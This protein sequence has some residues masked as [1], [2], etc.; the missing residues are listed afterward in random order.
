MRNKESA[1]KGQSSLELLVTLSFGLIILLPIVA[2]AFLQISSSSSTLSAT[3]AQQVG[4]KLA[5]VAAL[6]GSQGPPA[7]QLT[8]V[9]IPPGVQNIYVG[10]LSNGVGHFIILSISTTG[11]LDNVVSYT[12]VNV[13]G[14][15]G[16]LSTQGTYL[17]NVSADAKCP[18]NPAVS[19]VYISPAYG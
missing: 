13:S 19:C 3:A 14:N 11:G 5:T 12:P 10:N 16:G 8:T 7:R 15:I 2:L 1:H 9:E 6:V 4:S 17:L 18:S